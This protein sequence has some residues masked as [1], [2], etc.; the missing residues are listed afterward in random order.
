VI[1]EEKMIEKMKKRKTKIVGLCITIVM[2]CVI[3]VIGGIVIEKSLDRIEDNDYWAEAVVE[4]QNVPEAWA[5]LFSSCAMLAFG[6]SKIYVAIMV[7]ACALGVMAAQL[8]AELT[9]LG[10]QRII[11]SMWERLERLEKGAQE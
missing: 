9:G 10:R 4:T 5:Q 1:S 11:V 7:V 6:T 8:F 2:S 3:L